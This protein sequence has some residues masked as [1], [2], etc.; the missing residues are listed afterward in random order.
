LKTYIEIA[1]TSQYVNK[2]RNF[3]VMI[4]DYE[5]SKIEDG[6]KLRIEVTPGEH[7]IYLKNDWCRSNKLR[8]LIEESEHILFYCGCPIRGW[9][10]LNPFIMPFYIF[11][12]RDNYLY[13]N[14][15]ERND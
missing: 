14:R 15:L 6:G 7:E 2:L 1:R 10:Y 3:I 12:K 8:F 11:L 5:M 9:K 13:I 4:D